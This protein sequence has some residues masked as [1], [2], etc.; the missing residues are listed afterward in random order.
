MSPHAFPFLGPLPDPQHRGH[1][2]PRADAP[3][4]GRHGA[5]HLRDL[6]QLGAGLRRQDGADLPAQRRSRRRADPLEL[7]RAAARHPP[8]RQPAA[9]ARCR[10]E[11]RGGR[12]A[13]RLPRVPP[14]AVGRRGGGDRAAAQPAAERREAGVA[15]ANGRREGAD[16]LRQRR[17]VG[18]VVEGDAH[19]RQVP[20][21]HGRAARGAARRAR[22][23]RRRAAAGRARLR[24]AA[25]RPGRRP[26]GERPRDR[27][28]ATS[29][30]TSTPAAP[31]ARPSSPATATARRCSPP[32]PA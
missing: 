16:R 17:R 27:A 19:P 22:R 9:R 30:P 7:R 6:P 29:P 32:G 11:R 4:R 5:Q 1:P 25:R 10:A 28:A 15:D 21:L 24:G 3:R 13:A 2:P 26:A 31:P 14:R 18:H 23:R 12:A 20:T 8:D